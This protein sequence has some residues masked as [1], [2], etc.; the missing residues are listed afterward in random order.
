MTAISFNCA[1]CGPVCRCGEGVVGRQSLEELDFARSACAAAMNGQLSK[2]E[3]LLSRGRG[4]QSDGTRADASGYTPLHYAARNGHADCVRLLLR[5][6]A[7][8]DAATNGGATA[9]HRAAFGG[10]A[11]CVAL[12]CDAK[13]DASR[14]DSDGDAPLHKA[15][16]QGH[17]P[18]ADA[19]ARRCPAAAALR[20][21]KGR[22]PAD[23]AKSDELRA[24][25][26]VRDA[27]GPYEGCG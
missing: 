18:V 2:L 8:L 4:L 11:Q 17:A 13:A 15:A 12:L 7:D 23:V 19:L 20:N 6:C 9:L 16:A 24:R 25:L 3:S 14:Q 5:S 27:E 22:T 21:R 26:A 1:P 10:H